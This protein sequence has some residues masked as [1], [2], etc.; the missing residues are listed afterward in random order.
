MHRSGLTI[1]GVDVVKPRTVWR[2]RQRPGAGCTGDSPCAV[3]VAALHE[4][5]LRTQALVDEGLHAEHVPRKYR[6]LVHTKLGKRWGL[7][8]AAIGAL[9]LLCVLCKL[10]GL[11]RRCCKKCCCR[12]RGGGAG[13]GRAGDEGDGMGY[14]KVTP[15]DDIDFMDEGDVEMLVEEGGAAAESAADFVPVEGFG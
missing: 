2:K 6:D 13:A 14:A 8:F 12:R 3:V 1:D 7:V 10:C 9:L 4:V 5:D 11:L 15:G